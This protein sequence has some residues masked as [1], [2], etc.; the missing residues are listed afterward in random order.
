MHVTAGLELEA[1]AGEPTRSGLGEA[2]VSP[3]RPLWLLDAALGPT[4]PPAGEAERAA[5]LLRR[6]EVVQGSR[7]A[8]SF[9]VGGPRRLG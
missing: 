8:P 4:A 1:S 9:A 3:T 5:L 7:S 2:V 6:L